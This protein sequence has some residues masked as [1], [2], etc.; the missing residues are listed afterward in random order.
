MAGFCSLSLS[1][2]HTLCS[3]SPSRSTPCGR[4][5][6]PFCWRWPACCC[7]QVRHGRRLLHVYVGAQR[8]CAVCRRRQRDRL[9]R[10]GGT[11]LYL[12]AGGAPPH[13]TS[14]GAVLHEGPGGVAATLMWATLMRHY[15]ALVG[16][17]GLSRAGSRAIQRRQ[18]RLYLCDPVRRAGCK[19]H[20]G[21]GYAC[22]C[23]EH[24]WPGEGWWRWHI[25]V[26][27]PI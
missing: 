4:G 23:V 13:R 15:P 18:R 19:R 7:Q 22:F 25:V 26:D 14:G 10:E 2:T 16:G 9:G 20:S 5:P 3:L 8:A 27:K 12:G 6:W 17:R 1:H 11:V 21:G 24:A